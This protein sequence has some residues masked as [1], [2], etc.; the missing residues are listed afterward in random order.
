MH[1]I[2]GHNLPKKKRYMDKIKLLQL[3]LVKKPK[4]MCGG[5]FDRLDILFLAC[6]YTRYDYN[7]VCENNCSKPWLFAV[8]LCDPAV[9]VSVN[10][11]AL[12]NDEIPCN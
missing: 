8:K 5:L 9:P 12:D 10:S 6:V 3:W 11:G 2:L 1:I 7:K 4:L